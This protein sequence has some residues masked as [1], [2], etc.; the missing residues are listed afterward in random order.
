VQRKK[1]EKITLPLDDFLLPGENIR[2]QGHSNVEF[3]GNTY[4]VIVTDKRLVLYARRGFVFKND[5]V[6]T[7]VLSDIQGIRYRERGVIGRKGVVE[8][9]GRTKLELSGKPAEIKALNQ[10]L[11]QF[12]AK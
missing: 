3:A 6:I 5:D 12:M 11:T 7:E 9:H 10:N 2:F 4:R 1:E 8:V